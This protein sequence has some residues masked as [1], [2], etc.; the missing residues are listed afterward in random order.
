VLSG[1][2]AAAAYGILK[3]ERRIEVCRPAGRLRRQAGFQPHQRF[4]LVIRAT[5][6]IKGDWVRFGPIPVMSVSRLMIE[7]A[8]SMGKRQLRRAFIEAGRLDLLPS[9]CLKRCESRGSGF[10]GRDELNELIGFWTGGKG[11]VRSGL[12]GEFRLLCGEHGIPHPHRNQRVCGYEFDCLWPD[13]RLVVELDSRRF[14]DDEFGFENDRVKSNR[15][16]MAGYRLIRFTHHRVTNEPDA[17]AAEILL[18]L[19]AGAASEPV[20]D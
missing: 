5:P 13:A 11:K 10:K 7:L 12:E 19:E 4:R 9:E 14:H 20:G 17:V 3:P 18:M 16:A 15:L 6:F 1:H 8:G 2:S